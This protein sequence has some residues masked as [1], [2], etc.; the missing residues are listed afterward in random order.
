MS[1]PVN[2]VNPVRFDSAR[3]VRSREI[4]KFEKLHARHLPQQASFFKGKGELFHE[5]IL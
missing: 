4:L 5:L 1:Y 2:P 3:P